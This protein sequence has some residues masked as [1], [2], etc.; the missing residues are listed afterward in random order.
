[1]KNLIMIIWH[2]LSLADLFVCWVLYGLRQVFRS[3]EAQTKWLNKGIVD[4]GLRFLARYHADLKI[5]NQDHLQSIPWDDRHVFF[6]PNHQSY[7]DIPAVVGAA[8]RRVGFLAKKELRKIPFL[9]FWMDKIGCLMVDRQ[10]PTS[11]IRALK[12]LE[13]Q[14]KRSQ[15][16]L[17][18]EGTRSKDG[19]IAPIKEGGLKLL[20]ALKPIVVPTRIIG[21][22]DAMENRKSAWKRLP[23]TVTFGEPMDLKVLT[24]E[25]SF[26]EWVAQIEAFLKNIPYVP[27]VKVETQA[28]EEANAANTTGDQEN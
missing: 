24:K 27:P 7:A 13:K 20:W 16:A 14:G 4:W 11:V 2:L 6:V 18:P 12:D 21:T 15:L 8:G 5:E 25:I 19:Q 17:F 23:V 9:G 28:S 10:S 22:R 3:P 1:M 26:E